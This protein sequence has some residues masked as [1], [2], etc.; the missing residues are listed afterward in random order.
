MKA[1]PRFNHVFVV[2][3]STL[4][5]ISLASA[6]SSDSQRQAMRILDSSGVKGGLIVHSFRDWIRPL[7]TSKRLKTRSS[8]KVCTAK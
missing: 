5:V 4:C 6:R 2:I 3:L 7:Q 1:K 8:R